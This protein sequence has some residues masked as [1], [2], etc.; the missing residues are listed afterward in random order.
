MFINV[1][2]FC[3]CVWGEEK[4]EEVFGGTEISCKDLEYLGTSGHQDF[5]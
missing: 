2:S 4:T 5:S 3:V 1:F